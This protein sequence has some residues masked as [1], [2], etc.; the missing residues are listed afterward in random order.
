MAPSPSTT[1]WPTPPAPTST[2]APSWTPQPPTPTP[3]PSWTPQPPT[4]PEG[5]CRWG[6]WTQC[7]KS[8]GGGIATTTCIE[9]PMT[10]QTKT[11]PC[12]EHSCW[13]ECNHGC[14]KWGQF[15]DCSVSCGG[16]QQSRVCVKGSMGFKGKKETRSCS[17]KDCP[18]QCP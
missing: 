9:G 13:K 14:C 16:G 18:P 3:T 2:P 15:G 5:C 10:G 8:C 7:S 12:S 1:W 11:H 6:T 4:C 17:W